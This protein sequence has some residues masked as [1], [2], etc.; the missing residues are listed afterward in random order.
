VRQQPEVSPSVDDAVARLWAD[1]VKGALGSVYVE[2]QGG[3]CGVVGADKV[4]FAE[5]PLPPI[6]SG[7]Q[8]YRHFLEKASRTAFIRPSV[9]F[10]AGALSLH[11]TS[12][13]RR[14]SPV[15]LSNLN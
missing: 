10:V 1:R 4:G 2:N 7:W 8:V 15:V 14:K 3:T 9:E 11:A 5:I 12:T 6:R 13:P